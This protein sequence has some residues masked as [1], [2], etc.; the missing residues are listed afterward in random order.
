MGRRQILSLIVEEF[1]DGVTEGGVF[2]FVEGAA[3]FEPAEVVVGEL[4]ERFAL[5]F[6]EG[7][8]G[9]HGFSGEEVE[10]GFPGEVVDHL[11]E[12]LVE[13]HHVVEGAVG[14]VGGDAEHFAQ[15]LEA[16]S[17]EVGAV[18]ARPFEG[19]DKLPGGHL[20]AVPLKF[21]VEEEQ[22]EGIIVVGDEH[23]IGAAKVDERLSHLGK[24]FRLGD[25]FVGDIVDRTRLGGDRDA[26]VDEFDEGSLFVGVIGGEFD[27]AI[28]LGARPCGLGVVVDRFHVVLKP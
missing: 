19:V 1:F 2:G 16:V 12:D 5:V 17:G 26:G 13:D 21:F 14:L 6:A 10:D 3:A 9:E 8:V 24:G 4:F 20:Q 11:G 27:D 18:S 28:F 23:D 15:G 7:H 22:V 25:H